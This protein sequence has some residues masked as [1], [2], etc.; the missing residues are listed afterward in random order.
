MGRRSTAIKSQRKGILTHFS[1]L[2]INYTVASS[3]LELPG[4]GKSHCHGRSQKETLMILYCQ[5]RQYVS[6][7]SNLFFFLCPISISIY[8]FMSVHNK[9]KTTHYYLSVA[10]DDRAKIAMVMRTKECSHYA[11]MTMHH[12]DSRDKPIGKAI[13]DNVI[14]NNSVSSCFPFRIYKIP[15]EFRK[16]QSRRKC[17]SG[18]R[19]HSTNRHFGT[20]NVHSNNSAL[21]CSN[22]ACINSNCRPLLMREL[23]YAMDIFIVE[24]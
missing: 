9:W 8:P 11:S 22:T 2:E 7:E 24:E 19:I 15:L 16:L 1:N 6:A 17:N 21:L 23:H 20:P 5:Y 13:S 14:M 12:V 18:K 10:G 4:R 3:V